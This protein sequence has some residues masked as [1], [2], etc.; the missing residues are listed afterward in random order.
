M[1]FDYRG[2]TV[3]GYAGQDHVPYFL[4]RPSGEAWWFEY[5]EIELPVP[6]DDP[7][8]PTTQSYSRLVGI[9]STSGYDL[10]VRHAQ[11]TLASGT[12][13]PPPASW[14]Q[15]TGI[16]LGK[17]GCRAQTV[18]C[19]S[20]TMS[21]PAG[22][23]GQ[24]SVTDA[25]GRVTMVTT[26]SG[27][28]G[29]TRVRFPGS[30]VDDVIVN[31][32]DG[33]V[34]DVVSAGVKTTYAFADAGGVRTATV[35]RGAQPARVMRFDIASLHL[36]SEEW[37][38]VASGPTYK[39]TYDYSPSTTD[40][41][42]TLLKSVT[43]PEG[44][45]VRYA[46]D[47]RG[48]IVETRRVSKTPSA[49]ADIVTRA[50]FPAACSGATAL[51]CNKPLTR[52]DARGQVTEYSYDP[53]HGELVS[54]KGPAPDPSQPG[55][56]PETRYS[57][58]QTKDDGTVS[59]TNGIW[60]VTGISSCATGVSCVGT[61]DET[62]T[63]IAYG[64]GLNVTSVTRGAGD[65][66]VSATTTTRYDDVGNAVAVDGPLPGS[67]DTSYARYDVLRRPLGTVAPDPDGAGARNAQ[68][69]RTTY[70]VDGTVQ[71]V[72]TG[73]DTTPASGGFGGFT[74]LQAVTSS[75]DAYH[76]RV[77]DVL[78]AGG[79]T[80]AVSQQ[81]YDAFGRVECTVTR[82]DPAQWG[83]QLN[84]CLPQTTGAD[85]P[86][87]VV[88]RGYDVLDRVVTL[89]TG[90]GTL[91]ASSETTAY[92]ANGLV[93]SVKDAKG[94]STAYAYD[95]FDRAWRTCFQ[96]TSGAAC[97]GSPADYEQ[98][99]YAANGDVS[100]LRRRDGRLVTFGYDGLGRRLTMASVVNGSGPMV[101][102]RYDLRGRM[103]GS[104][105]GQA[106]ATGAIGSTSR[107]YAYD[108][109]DRVVRETDASGADLRR[110]YDAAGRRTRL[111]WSDG[112]FVTYD[113]D[114]AGAMTSIREN[115][116]GLL[117][118]YG[119]DQLGRRTMRT[120]GNG[121]ATSYGYDAALRL[122]GLSLTG[123]TQ[124][125]AVSFGYNAAG[126]I[127]SRTGSNDAYAWGGA[128]NVDRA[129]AVN[130]L[131]QYT[132]SGTVALGYDG[133]GNLTGS[134]NASYGYDAWNQ[135]TTATVSGAATTLGYDAN[136]LIATVGSARWEWDGGDLVTER[137][138]GA[139]VR[140]YVHGPGDDEPVLWYEGSGTAA[141]NRRWLDAD[142]R[143]SIVR[144]TN[145]AGTAL[146]VNG[147]DEFGIPGSGNM[148]RFQYTGQLWMPE[149]GLYYYKAR[150]YSPTLG[151]FLQT[152]PTG[153]DDGLNWYDYVGGDPVNGTDP[154]GLCKVEPV[155]PTAPEKKIICKIGGDIRRSYLRDRNAAF[156]LFKE[157][158][159]DQ[160]V[161]FTIFRNRKHGNLETYFDVGGKSGVNP[162]FNCPGLILILSGHIHP[163][164]VGP[165]FPLGWA[166][167]GPSE[168]DSATS[169]H[170]SDAVFVLYE[171]VSETWRSRCF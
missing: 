42:G 139:I 16:A 90:Y 156:R 84:P 141:A 49:A 64:Y 165:I 119:C 161:S 93:A 54:E 157:T 18:P 146:A 48:N 25:A 108:A 2:P 105:T 143:G 126:Q 164:P 52:T 163:T 6:S 132:A 47:V 102:Y 30:T 67:G 79:Q 10:R 73:T 28:P 122:V 40:P 120:L 22:T 51:F 152:D 96:T 38:A 117:A 87:R 109:L 23:D 97:A 110:G 103:T 77:K 133:R 142:E 69:T 33:K 39:R 13:G 85:E 56:R 125:N 86:D 145:D 101:G 5:E 41:D 17:R 44:N 98:T 83:G 134:G 100:S 15:S 8:A 43:E 160:E 162:K 80:F 128:V 94:N 107:T 19:S 27:S 62:K 170:Y 154:T 104:T 61:A 78:T 63:V 116:S 75:Y 131:N 95:G 70:N 137:T 12:Q 53:L 171:K 121:T 81:S 4:R 167:P 3:L 150:M 9:E 29:P 21:W 20:L 124:A 32:A 37:Q 129:Y 11:E 60:L 147:Y 136:G 123:G 14:G 65:N 130:G 159:S 114:A 158:G 31:Y 82:M 138:G 7:N 71:R 59:A 155:K 166:P 1:W 135:L 111:T 55:L 50:T 148:G 45:S 88:R 153:Y 140:R 58:T 46:Y 112:F 34:S 26:P 74:A 57:Y 72:E 66:S 89:T 151:R 76:R 36:L 127:A 169:K 144:V 68:A 106:T 91:V 99:S 113:Y 35:T 24:G 118:S 92:S 149:L 168:A 115:G